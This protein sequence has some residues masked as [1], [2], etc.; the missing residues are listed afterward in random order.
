MF[1]FYIHIKGKKI[2]K[3]IFIK[4]NT[5]VNYKYLNFIL[6]CMHAYVS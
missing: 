3:D 1:S 2:I 6:L 4:K 5:L